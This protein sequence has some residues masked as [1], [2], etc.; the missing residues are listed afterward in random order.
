MKI[1]EIQAKSII[2]KS[3]LPDSDLVINPYVGCMHGCI[4]CYARFMKRFT[5]H[6]EAWGKFVDVKIN[7]PD[8]ID[9]EMKKYKGEFITIGSV[10][11]PYHPIEINYKLTRKIL[12]KLLP[13]QPDFDI[14]TKSDLVLRDIDLIKRFKHVIIGVS[15]SV[16]DKNL[17]KSLEPL[18][19]S[20]DRRIKAL[21]ELH[22][23]G[24]KNALF[25]SPMSPY[26]TNWKKII[27][28]TK[29]FVDEYWFENLNLYPS[30]KKEIYDFLFKHKKELIKE[31][32]KIEANK[33]DYWKNV[34]REIIDFCEKEKVKYRIYFYHGRNKK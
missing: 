10:T 6:K 30:V 26:L 34:E 8:L 14:L 32:K 3:N 2:T 20:P 12:E 24:I 13:Y 17:N 27:L 29:K 23:N 33:M 25:I 16:L 18:A 5:G 21:K 31:Y 15:L 7:A 28:K 19:S 11:D 22:K 1:K 9:K 4:Y